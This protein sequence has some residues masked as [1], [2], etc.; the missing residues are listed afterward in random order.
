MNV[1]FMTLVNKNKGI[2]VIQQNE[3]TGVKQWDL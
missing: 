3:I 1:N 2:K